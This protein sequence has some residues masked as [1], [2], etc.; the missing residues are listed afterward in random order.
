M[1]IPERL[2]E[3]AFVGKV[4]KGLEFGL[5]GDRAEAIG[6]RIRF[7]SFGMNESREDAGVR[8]TFEDSTY[9]FAYDS[10]GI[11]VE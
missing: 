4:L 2:L 1:I 9:V 8:L 3:A 7:A 6:K 10:E 5:E 11:T